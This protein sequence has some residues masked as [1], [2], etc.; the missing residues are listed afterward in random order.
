MR[1]ETEITRLVGA[2][3]NLKAWLTEKGVSVPDAALL[4]EIVDLLDGVQTAN[5]LP[6][7]DEVSY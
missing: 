3:A 2:K 1:I 5:D 4:P 6:N 7:G